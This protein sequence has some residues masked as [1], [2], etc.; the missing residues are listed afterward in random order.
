M[1]RLDIEYEGVVSGWHGGP[2]GGFGFV[3]TSSPIAGFHHRRKDCAI[4]V[5]WR[6]LPPEAGSILK[7]G[8][9]IAFFL[10]HP[11]DET[12]DWEAC[13]VRM[14]GDVS[15]RGAP[16]LPPKGRAKLSAQV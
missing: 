11:R 14:L 1:P 6:D 16:S 13:K 3:K 2:N 7:N 5:H 8:E 10:K 12:K 15:D 9:S 4:F